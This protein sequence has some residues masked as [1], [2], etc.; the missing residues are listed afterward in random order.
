MVRYF[1]FSKEH[2]NPT[3]EKWRKFLTDN[4][5]CTFVLKS[6]KIS[7]QIV[8]FTS[9]HDPKLKASVCNKNGYDLYAIGGG[10]VLAFHSEERKLLILNTNGMG[11]QR[12]A[13]QWTADNCPSKTADFTATDHEVL[14]EMQTLFDQ[15]DVPVRF[16]ERR[17]GELTASIQNSVAAVYATRAEF[18]CFRIIFVVMIL[19]YLGI[20]VGLFCH[21]Q[22]GDNL[23]AD[24][25]GAHSN[26]IKALQAGTA[27][28][29]ELN[30]ATT[31][32]LESALATT[33]AL[34]KKHEQF[35]ENFATI[36]QKQE[37]MEARIEETTN[38]VKM[39]RKDISY[40]LSK[41]NNTNSS[42]IG[43]GKT[44]QLQIGSSDGGL[45]LW[46]LSLWSMV[47][48]FISFVWNLA[49]GA[50][51]FVVIGAS[52]RA[53]VMT[54]EEKKKRQAAKVA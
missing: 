54:P 43:D 29:A 10:F 32:S 17:L 5:D 23:L 36:E 30:T 20:L 51:V 40:I 21:V 22:R 34:S 48:M 12:H 27:V 9:T 26:E 11:T 24:A 46:T 37:N 7:E 33:K 19:A 31:K 8:T 53:M 41:V 35:S 49:I 14:A 50:L 42:F 38:D 13:F 1:T 15:G 44:E 45:S 39:L 28:Q 6:V 25:I 47:S 2:A 4:W 16:M 52:V 3:A 18:N